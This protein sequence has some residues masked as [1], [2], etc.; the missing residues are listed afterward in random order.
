[1]GCE[2]GDGKWKMRSEIYWMKRWRR[3]GGLRGLGPRA[4]CRR[5]GMRIGFAVS[6]TGLNEAE[7]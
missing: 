6:L 5:K 7:I 3:S 1:M 2:S 4:E